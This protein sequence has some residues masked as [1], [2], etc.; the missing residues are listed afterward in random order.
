VTPIDEAGQ[1]D[2]RPA[3]IGTPV[4]GE[5]TGERRDDVGAAV[6]VDGSRQCLDLAGVAD[7]AEVVAQPLDQ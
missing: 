3:R 5:Q 1:A 7:D 6:V 4:R 2:D